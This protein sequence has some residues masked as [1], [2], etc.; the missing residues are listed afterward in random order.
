[1]TKNNPIRA[2]IREETRQYNIARYVKRAQDAAGDLEICRAGLE[3]VEDRARA[4]VLA[5]ALAVL[6]DFA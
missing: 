1:M 4:A 3:R 2:Q 5:R 6:A